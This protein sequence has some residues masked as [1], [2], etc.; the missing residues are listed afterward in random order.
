MGTH[1]FDL[2]ATPRPSPSRS[3]AELWLMQLR[4]AMQAL[5]LALETA[6]G[7]DHQVPAGKAAGRFESVRALLDLQPVSRSAA[8]MD[9][10]VTS[11]RS[12][13]ACLADAYA[14]FAESADREHASTDLMRAVDAAMGT[15][16]AWRV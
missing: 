6:A 16:P 15:A 12:T 1:Q 11:I 13:L 10:R 3:A 7:G 5:I 9:G 8:S 14:R 2:R 4:I